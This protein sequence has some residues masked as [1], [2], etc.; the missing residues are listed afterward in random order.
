MIA[1]MLPK[2]FFKYEQKNEN[3]LPTAI[4][5][6]LRQPQPKQLTKKPGNEILIWQLFVL[7]TYLVTLCE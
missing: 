3:S 6:S 1:Y 4:R 5:V 2:N 7:H